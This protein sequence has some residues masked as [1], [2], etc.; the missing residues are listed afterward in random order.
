MK[1]TVDFAR[2]LSYA[3]DIIYHIRP[4]LGKYKN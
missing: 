2:G 4:K 3:I 1:T